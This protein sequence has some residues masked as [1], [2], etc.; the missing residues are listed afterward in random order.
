MPEKP[1]FNPNQPYETANTGKPKFNPNAGYSVAED[2]ISPIGKLAV[3]DESVQVPT[4]K[5]LHDLEVDN[6]VNF[7]KEKGGRN[8]STIMDQ[9]LDLLRNVL[10]NP[11]ATQEQRKN[12]ILT[13]QGYDSKHSDD[14]TM[15]YN[16]LEDNGVYMPTALAYGERPPKG[17]DMPSIWGSQDEANDD[18]WY[19][20]LG[21]SLANGVL[22]AAQGAVNLAQ[23]GTTLATGEESKYLNK[24]VNTAEILKFKKDID[25]ATPIY[26]T[27]GI[28]S[29]GDLVSK[30]RFDLSPKALW[31]TL[32]MAGE[33]LVSFYG[34][35][36]GASALINSPKAT[37]FTGSFM[38]Q[39]GDNLDNAEAAGLKGR[40]KAAVASLITAPMA[41]LDSFFG[42]DGKIMS[43]TFKDAKKEFIKNAVKSVEKDAAGNITE[44]GFKELAKITSAGYGQLAKNG[45][46]EVVKDVLEEG[47]Q[48][49]AQDFTQ[50]A[51]EQL[52][53][54]LSDEDKAKFGTNA[55]D[56]KSFGS[57]IQS[58]GAGLVGGAPM[59]LLNQVIK[60][61]NQEQSSTVYDRI[62]QG[63]EAVSA[64][65]AD[66]G[67]SLK[68]NQITQDEYDNANFKINAYQNYN[69]LTQKYNMKPEDEKR[70]FELS[71]QIEGLN[72]E[73]PTDKQEI[74][75]MQP[76]EK[77]EVKAK[78]IQRNKL[79]EELDGIILKSQVKT[80]PVVAKKVEE[81]IKSEEEKETPEVKVTEPTEKTEEINSKLNQKEEV[82]KPIRRKLQETP[83]EEFNQMS[84]LVKK[85]TVQEHL[86]DK[87]DMSMTG[88]IIIEQNG[89]HAV[90][91]G[92]GKYVT[93]ASSVE[94]DK[95]K[96]AP[97]RRE[98][99]PTESK[100]ENKYFLNE[101]RI[102]EG[103]SLNKQGKANMPVTS[104]EA[105]VIVKRE[106]IHSHDLKTDKPE[107]NKDG[108]PK[109]DAI[110][111]VYNGQTGKYIISVRE[112]DKK[113][114]KA[115]KPSEYSPTEIKQMQAIQERGVAP[116]TEAD[117]RFT[118][119]EENI[120]LTSEVNKVE[121]SVVE[122][123]KPTEKVV[124]APKVETKKELKKEVK[125]EKPKE[126]VE[127]VKAEKIETT[128]QTIDRLIREGYTEFEI[129][130]AVDEANRIM[131]S[132][133]QDFVKEMNDKAMFAST[134]QVGEYR[135]DTRGLTTEQVKSAIKNITEGKKEDSVAVKTFTQEVINKIKKTGNVPLIS[136]TG[137]MTAR[138]DMPLYE[139]F[140]EKGLG[141][142]EITQAEEE[143][144]KTELEYKER[145]KGLKQKVSK[146]KDKAVK[147]SE[148]VE[149]VNKIIDSLKK[150]MPKVNFKLD[151]KIEGA[152]LWNP[153]TNTISI[154]P[155]YSGFDTPIHEAGHVLIDVIG[156]ENKVVQK[157]VTQLKDTDL[158]K[159]TKERYPE[160][161]DR[162][163]D[164]EVLS[165]AIG[166]EGSDIFDKTEDK[167]KFMQ[168]LEYIFDWLKT[169]LGLNKNIA[170]SLA[171]QI[172]SGI[173]TKKLE[174]KE[175][176][177]SREQKLKK[178]EKVKSYAAFRESLGR[179]Y[180]E[181]KEAIEEAEYALESETAT[182][183]EK[184]EAQKAI[185]DIKSQRK[186]DNKAYREYI[187][188]LSEDLS[189]Y[190][191]EE[192]IDL[193]SQI[194]GLNLKN[195]KG[196][197]ELM[198][199]IAFRLF[200]DR[201]AE[202]SDKHKDYIE[203]IA[204]TKDIDF[205]DVWML[206]GSHFTE[207][208]PEMQAAMNKV[209]QAFLNK[210]KDANDLKQTN[211]TLAKK[212]IKEENARIGIT[213]Q[214]A[215]SISSDSA[216][217]FEWMDNGQG[218]LI[219]MDQ[220][221]AKGYSKARLDYLDF[222][223][224]LLAERR[225]MM[226]A[227]NYAN[228][229][230]E[231]IRT[232][233]KFMESFRDDGLAQAFSYYLGGGGA[234]L[235]KV[236]IMYNGKAE[237]FSEIEKDIIS[238]ANKGG[239]VEKIKAII[240]LIRY[241]YMARKQLKRGFNVDE[242]VNPLGKQPNAK[243]SLNNNG[244]LVSKFDR[245]RNKDR[246]YSRDFYRAMI[247]Y[248]DDTSHVKHMNE[249]LPI[250][251]A[252]EY[253]NKNG[254]A[255][256]GIIAKDNVAKW[257]KEWKD[258]HIFDEPKVNDPALDAT[259]K[260]FRKLTAATTMWFNLPANLINVM[261]GNYN[262]FRQENGKTIGKGNARLFLKSGPRKY[263]VNQYALDI[264]EKY[265]V[266]NK[267]YDSNPKIG[268]G[269]IFD[270]LATIGTQIGE[271]QIQGSLALGL[272]DEKDFDSF[273]YK[274]DKYG[275]NKL[276]VKE[277][278]SEE[279]KKSLE[280][281]IAAIKDRVTDIQGKYPDEQ[282]RN[283]MR[284][285][286]AKAVFQFKVWIPDYLRERFAPRYINS[287]NQIKEGTFNGLIKE[288]F[289]Q[290]RDDINKK[291][292]TR[293][294][295]ENKAFTSNIKGLMAITTL[296]IW[297]YQDDDDESK[298][299]KATM[300]E[301][302]LGQVLFITDPEQLK[303]MLGNPVAALGKMKDFVSAAEALVTLETNAKGEYTADEKI[304]RVIPA[305][306]LS[307]IAEAASEI[308]E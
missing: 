15:Y 50:K 84:S 18:R 289:K 201:Q 46:K 39:L 205:I 128:Q 178:G 173:G 153:T 101:G 279:E 76:I 137:G 194:K 98:N 160:L 213:G 146:F 22:G 296:L 176:T 91:L 225:N 304:K 95:T 219:T 271:Y 51:G 135:I 31:G 121:E 120:P 259:I 226:E 191:N 82:V 73:I 233:K 92:G 72:T 242:R 14:N 249:V 240:D 103:A 237:S 55:F 59:T 113:G 156:Y 299:R 116:L 234:N 52:W 230:M 151:D 292:L 107:F 272:M 77:G 126:K 183:E 129:E 180:Y 257:I 145:N 155:E 48:E 227:D 186:K 123:V 260:F 217:Y 177:I 247:E 294:L 300:A 220:A 229:D 11:N 174:A 68:N 221:K 67:N 235:G 268:L 143:E 87:P 109:M 125:V 232:D 149:K 197:G 216:K 16:K 141:K 196:Q 97:I 24:L 23:V 267:D 124:E 30:D 276:V 150:N 253:L 53:D 278:L 88:K 106:E 102:E 6:A 290:L 184:T 288:G 306:K 10:K 169:K 74:H 200:K 58:L 157:A 61:K 133:N 252:V 25:L 130:R 202:I 112:K 42:L 236:R 132:S 26:N 165:E 207:H 212:V 32:N 231:V 256:K 2:N 277:S 255:E 62:K 115:Y 222:T 215:N 286:I 172:I 238:K 182:E 154:N 303:Y 118:P 195:T 266:V 210:V 119:I 60:G 170:K 193:Y 245:P 161:S 162:D 83:R 261:V 20:D 56:A 89:K 171:K 45:A 185:N 69:D 78:E 114:Y 80:E 144:F 250:V 208:Q 218:S 297:K 37:V 181:E 163:L 79:Q 175:G 134:G 33:S 301:N 93:L 94:G 158:Y 139:F 251:D 105:P 65:K 285:E 36:K 49:A 44:Q 262:N 100:V 258:L 199:E 3:R 122:Q 12:A 81:F 308:I 287:R 111:N 127:E 198:R 283:I 298:R 167:N 63:P 1:K 188:S 223:R 273:E 243:Y 274:K 147:A 179:E 241:N 190:N 27:E 164:I 43:N 34:G 166:R 214:A 66:L 40:D 254:Y 224:N 4:Y 263:G 75:R 64:L 203:S 136:G 275:N 19:T 211:E 246:G 281:K 70:A 140:L 239:V 264:L 148:R 142:R 302:T 282:R 265:N 47:G 280:E 307:N 86:K 117:E 295:W 9:E 244:I 38:S 110:L 13:I 90:D 7:I 96:P 131:A 5:N 284:G 8:G 71:F 108:T 189:E 206:N 35:S 54:K 41:A 269:K 192:L 270:K 29:F 204:K 291:G 293:G 187:K 152:G 28:Q 159:E 57:Y 168:Y 248:I 17:Y 99:L 21:K 305:N 209:S 85:Q 228:A 104:Y 138:Y